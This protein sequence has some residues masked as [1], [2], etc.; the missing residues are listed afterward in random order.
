MT[1]PEAEIRLQSRREA[2]PAL[3]AAL[4]LLVLLAAV[5]RTEGWELLGWAGWWVW[6]LVAAPEALLL[7]E[8]ALGGRWA[9]TQ[10]GRRVAGVLLAIL[11]AATLGAL[12]ILLASLVR[13]SSELGGGELLLTALAI[14]VTVVIV[15]GLGFW[16]LDCGGPIARARA[17]MRTTPDFQFPQDENP[18]L[19]PPGWRPDVWDY[20]YL[21]LTNAIA[22]S[23]TDAMPLS[24][25]AKAL[26]GLGSLASAVTVL[27]VAARAVNVLGG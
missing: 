16:E 9:D 12:G 17:R 14:W 26:M 1:G 20:V 4:V 24:R 2:A 5:S 21:S 25:R 6:L 8:L 7:A 22:F 18:S 15:F 19:A 27:L 10:R 3:A 11:I 23:P 13:T